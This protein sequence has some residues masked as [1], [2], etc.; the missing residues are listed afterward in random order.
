MKSGEMTF[1][2]GEATGALPGRT[3]RATDTG[4]VRT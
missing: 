3:L 4:V 1:V 2:G